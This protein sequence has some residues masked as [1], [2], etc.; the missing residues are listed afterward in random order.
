M[1]PYESNSNPRSQIRIN[2]KKKQGDVKGIIRMSEKWM[3]SK[4]HTEQEMSTARCE[5]LHEISPPEVSVSRCP[6]CPPSGLSILPPL[7]PA[8]A[9]LLARRVR[10]RVCMHRHLARIATPPR[11]HDVV[12][13][14]VRREG[15]LQLGGPPAAAWAHGA[16]AAQKI[17][18]ASQ[19]ATP[20]FSTPQ[21]VH[22][23]I[24]RTAA[25][26]RASPPPGSSHLSR[27]F[28][29]SVA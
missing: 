1:A 8:L 20:P 7:T 5:T 22:R 13:Q 26:I 27:P 12:G 10:E 11:E 3:R 25:R 21:D 29:E 24:A 28:R 23:A 9:C 15:G 18:G 17:R 6:S 16:A 4:K 19:R 2:M 14:H